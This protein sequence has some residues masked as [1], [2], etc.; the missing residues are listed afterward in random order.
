MLIVNG[1]NPSVSDYDSRT[2]LHL[3][4]SCGRISILDMLLSHDPPI[5]INPVDRLGG[6]PLEDAYRYVCVYALSTECGVCPAYIRLCVC[7]CIYMTPI[8]MY[9]CALSVDSALGMFIYMYV[10][11]CMHGQHNSS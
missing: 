6:T 8:G 7:M 3:A 2:S 5:E 10:C 9:V 11:V 1:V 4:A